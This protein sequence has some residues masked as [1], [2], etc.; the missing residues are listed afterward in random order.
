[1]NALSYPIKQI[2]ENAGK[3][4]SVI[5]NKVLENSDVNFGYDAFS[6]TYVN[7]LESGI[8][9]P[10]KVERVAMEEAISLA[11]MFLTTEAAVVELPK[12]DEPPHHH[13][14]GMG[15]MG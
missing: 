12:K 7:M 13:G 15:G 10:A 2:V 9:D 14:G 3:E 4:G 5:V 6:D 8:I 11:G 1:M